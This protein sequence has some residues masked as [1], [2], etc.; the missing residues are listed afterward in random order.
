MLNNEYDLN[1]IDTLF[2][3]TINVVS[4]VFMIHKRRS[5]QKIKKDK[6]KYPSSTTPNTVGEGTKGKRR[7][8]GTYQF[9]DINT[10]QRHLNFIK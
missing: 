4:T 1:K 2:Q 5:D 8:E 10:C 7:G 3:Q 9:A 6:V